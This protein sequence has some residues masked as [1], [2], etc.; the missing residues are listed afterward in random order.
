MNSADLRGPGFTA[1]LVWTGWRDLM[2]KV[3][4]PWELECEQWNF[5]GFDGRMKESPPVMNGVNIFDGR[6][7]I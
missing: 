2:K 1:I 6:R 4:K 7:G 5:D 3:E